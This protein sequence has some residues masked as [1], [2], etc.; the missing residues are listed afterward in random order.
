MIIKILLALFLLISIKICEAQSN[1]N[2]NSSLD[3]LIQ[4]EMNLQNLPGVSTVIVKE[5][6]IVWIES[7]GYADIENNIMVE[8]TTVFLLASMSKLFTG[9]AVMQLHENEQIN[10]DE[11][12][13]NHLPYVIDI[14]N[15]TSD[16]ITFRTLMTH[17]GS[18][19]DNQTVMDTYYDYPDP[20]MS[21]YDCIYD[22]FA[23]GGAQYDASNNFFNN[24]PGTY[25]SY[26]N[27]G[28]ALNGLLVESITGQG[29][30]QYCDVNIFEPL[31]MSKTSWFMA[32]FDTNHVA[33]PYQYSGGNYVPYRHY[34]FAD[35]PD[36]QLRSNVK[37]LGNFMIAYL[38]G[39]VFGAS[40]ILS[41]TS[42]NEMLSP[43]IPSLDNTQ[44]LNWYQEELFYNSGAN[45]EMLWGH[46]GGEDGVSTDMY[47]DPT[48]NIGICVLT[49]GEGDGLFICDGLYDYARTL[50]SNN[51]IEVGCQSSLIEEARVSQPYIYPN[52]AV[53]I[54]NIVV[55]SKNIGNSYIVTD[56]V[57]KLIIQSTLTKENT[58]LDISSYPKGVYFISIQ[59][60][61][62]NN[63]IRFMIE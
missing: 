45:S 60:N 14:P 48:N 13:N 29:F 8:D 18:I 47:L 17:T 5:G 9:T 25:Y 55:T 7:Y 28:T 42:I 1:P 16:S 39:G 51:G 41:T 26:S 59:G 33:R 30:N 54:L 27:M 49:N 34:G 2:P 43:Q 62:K 6:K 37:D 10:L 63:S 12:I 20:S 21:L 40:S 58:R 53:E 46:N 4:S 32:D 50:S 11:D 19:K 36:G 44:G 57:G 22:Y 38:N 56:N 24:S 31:C 15:F 23:M 61:D 3:A 35:Y 52:P